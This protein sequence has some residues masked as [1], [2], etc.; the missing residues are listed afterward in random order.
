MRIGV[1]RGGVPRRQLYPAMVAG[2]V[3][4]VPVVAAIV[5][6]ALERR[7]GTGGRD[8]DQSR[9]PDRS[10]GAAL[11]PGVGRLRHDEGPLRG[12]VIGATTGA[13]GGVRAPHRRAG[14]RGARQHEGRADEARPDGELPRPG[15]ARAG[16]RRAGRAAD[17]TPRRWRPSWPP[18]RRAP[19]SGARPSE[20]FAEWDPVPIAAA[21]IGQVHRADHPRRPGGRGQGAV[22]GRR[23]GRCRPTST[24]PACCSP[25]WPCCSR[26]ST[27][28]RSSAELRDRLVEELDYRERGA[29]TSGCSPTSTRATRTS[30]CPTSIHE[31]STGAGAHH[32]AG[33]RRP[34][35]RGAR[36]GSQDERNLAAETHL[37]L[38]VRR[39]ST[40][41]A[42]STAIRI[43]AT[44]CSAP[45]ARSRSSTSAWCKRF[46]PDELADVR[47]TDPRRW[48]IDHDL[49]RVPRASSRRIGLLTPGH[50]VHRRAARATTSGTSTSS[51]SSDGPMHDHAGVRVGDR[52]P[53][54]R[55]GGPYGEIIEVGQPARRRW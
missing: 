32:R 25:R 28:S 11:G 35:R 41:C 2:V 40:G 7:I 34:L 37:P 27:P 46:T 24:T 55:P 9:T 38:R 31:L 13:A 3:V 1:R 23:R 39:R 22:P 18:G 36:R 4:V 14:R 44:T 50:D 16:P 12:G 15:P 48:C 43:R 47:A 51:S 45:A 20:V 21:S 30:T 5:I 17:T 53:L 49:G 52:P 42:R 8:V 10:T 6:R 54:L 33:R 19:S 26:A 29:R